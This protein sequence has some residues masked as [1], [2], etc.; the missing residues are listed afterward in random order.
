MNNLYASA[1]TQSSLVTFT[2]NTTLATVTASLGSQSLSSGASAYGLPLQPYKVYKSCASINNNFVLAREIGKRSY[3]LTDHLGN[4]RAVLSDM[5]IWKDLTS[6]GGN[7]DNLCTNNEM[8]TD[9]KAFTDYYAFG[10]P[11]PGR[12]YTRSG[13]KYRYGFNGK[14]KDDE[15]KGSGNSY[16]FGARIYDPRI[17][18]FLS[19]DKF[20]GKF[21]ALSPYIFAGNNPIWAID[22]NGDSAVVFGTNGKFLKIID[23][24]KPGYVGVYMNPKSGGGKDFVIF[25]F[26]DPEEDVKAIRQGIILNVKLVDKTY[27]DLKVTK[28]LPKDLN[29]MS[30]LDK[31]FYFKDQGALLLDIGLELCRSEDGYKNIYIVNNKGY[32]VADFGNFLIGR[33]AGKAN[34]GLFMMKAGGYVN[35]LLYSRDQVNSCYDNLNTNEG[36]YDPGILDSDGD[37]QAIEDGYNYP[38]PSSEKPDRSILLERQGW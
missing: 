3:E 33:A 5:R 28:S 21:P 2:H 35:H 14:E 9:V 29:T 32:N 25:N 12:N 16:D 22:K 34:I 38:N 24:G 27:I 8:H 26:N 10:M 20:T 18:K 36:Y 15:I 17:A 6:E 11:M 31:F 13:G 23:N 37:Q 7:G 19:T 30:Y 4:V 1:P